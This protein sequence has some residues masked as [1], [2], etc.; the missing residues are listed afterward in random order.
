MIGITIDYRCL[1]KSLVIAFCLFLLAPTPVQAALSTEEQALLDEILESTGQEIPEGVIPEGIRSV[2]EFENFLTEQSVENLEDFA[3]EEL[4]I[5]LDE[6]GSI[7]DFGEIEDLDDFLTGLGD[8]EGVGTIEELR[9]F[10]DLQELEG[11]LND[12]NL[13]DVASLEDLGGLGEI[14]GNIE[15]VNN[16]SDLADLEDILGNIV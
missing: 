1:Q 11:V 7:D 13:D 5:F 10:A 16:I 15:G 6:I 2:E 8:I 14:L 4:N 3:P 9:D 12:I